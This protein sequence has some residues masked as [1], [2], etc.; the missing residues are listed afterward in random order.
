[1]KLIDNFNKAEQAIHDHVGYDGYS[2]V[3]DDTWREAYWWFDADNQTLEW[4]NTVFDPEDDSAEYTNEVKGLYRGADFT[5]A[6]ITSDYGDDDYLLVL[7]NNK[8]IEYD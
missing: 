2:A 8:E 7:N 5:L 1:M 3:I 4:Q 6:L